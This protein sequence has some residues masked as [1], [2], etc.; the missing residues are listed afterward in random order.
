VMGLLV[1]LLIAVVVWKLWT[2]AMAWAPAFATLLE[3]PVTKTGFLPF[4][5]GLET[6][7]GDFEGRPVLLALHHKRGRNSLGYLVVAMQPHTTSGLSA[8]ALSTLTTPEVREALEELEG[9]SELH[10][11]LDDGWLKARWQPGGFMVFPGQFEPQ[12]WRCVLQAMSVVNRS[13]ESA[14]T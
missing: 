5:M 2:P 12:R 11:S 3:R 1:L 10:V 4:I 7:G 6:A 14:R 13:L 8:D 9:R